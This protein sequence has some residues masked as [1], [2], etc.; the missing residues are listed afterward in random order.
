MVNEL[1]VGSYFNNIYFNSNYVSIVKEVD[2]MPIFDIECSDCGQVFESIEVA[3]HHK[4]TECKFCK[5]KNI[6]RIM[7]GCTQVRMDSD[8]VLKSV[9]DPVPP[10]SELE[11]KTKP[12]CEGGFADKPE[13]G[14]LNNYTR[15]KDKYGN[16]IW[17]QKKRVYFIPK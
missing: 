9:P 15:S 14:N 12:G 7:S 2:V 13:G 17:K 1:L 3:S 5:S 10:L 11:G 6:K 8:T 4:A 16:T